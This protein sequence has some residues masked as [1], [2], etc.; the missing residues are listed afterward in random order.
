MTADNKRVYIWR[1]D[2]DTHNNKVW[3][4]ITVKIQLES[5]IILLKL[6]QKLS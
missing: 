5:C 4:F 6:Y 1:D 2:D 3:L